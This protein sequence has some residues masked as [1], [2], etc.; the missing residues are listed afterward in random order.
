MN[1]FSK[2]KNYYNWGGR[3]LNDPYHQESKKLNEL[4]MAKRP[5]RYDV[6]N[7]LLSSLNRECTYLEIGVRNPADNFN[8]IHATT[9][10][11]VDPGLE[12]KEN[13]VDFVLTSDQFFDQLRAGEVLLTD[14]QFDVIFIDGLHTAEQVDRDIKNALE[15]IKEDGFIVLH[16]CNPPTESHAREEHDYRLS[17]AQNAWNGTTWKGF[18]KWRRNALIYS[19]TIDTDWGIGIISKTKNIGNSSA[20]ENEF[21]EFQIFNEHR[22]ESL[23]L[24]SFEELSKII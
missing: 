1:R 2:L 19:C 21:Y 12:F 8:R 7:F 9:K 10:Y 16:D 5:F 3:F 23:N 14:I 17:P 18:M 6:I 4:E 24:I 20:T 13:P 11:S 15:F 22:M